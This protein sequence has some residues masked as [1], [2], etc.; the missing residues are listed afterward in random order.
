M[1]LRSSEDA[2]R[3]AIAQMSGMVTFWVVV[4]DLEEQARAEQ[5][6][7]AEIM[8]SRIIP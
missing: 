4:I 2:M 7:L 1:R 6:V 8:F 5:F 3:A